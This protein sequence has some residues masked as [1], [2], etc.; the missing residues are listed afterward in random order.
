MTTPLYKKLKE[1]GTSFYAFASAAEDISAAYQ[2]DNYRMY[3]SKYV[4]LNFPKQ[5]TNP[6]GTQAVPT[7]FDFATFSTI[8]PVASISYQDQVIE[9]LRNYVA[10]N[11]VTLR[12]S[13]LNNTEYYYDTRALETTSEKI[14]W[15]WCKKLNLIDYEPAIP[16]DEYFSNLTE[17]QRVDLTDDSYF[18]EYLWKEKEPVEISVSNYDTNI[19]T[20]VGNLQ[21]E[22]NQI[23]SI[24]KGDVIEL[25][26][27]SDLGPL[28]GAIW[29]GSLTWL[30]TASMSVLDVFEIA[31]IQY[32]VVDFIYSGGPFIE[33]SGKVKVKYNKLIQ[34][35]GEVTGVSNVQE[36]NRAYTEVYAHVPDHT[37]QTPDIL[38]RTIADINYK[39]GMIF[40]IIPSQYQPEIIGAEL[41]SSPIV[42]NPTQ[43]PG[44]YYGQFDTID[45][46]YECE[47]G[48]TLRRS[49]KY[50]GVSGDINAPVI[51]GSTL[52]GVTVDF[53]TTHYAKMNIND[54]E[55]ATFDEFNALEI[56][57]MP[58]VDFEFNAILWYY[59]VEDLNGNR[60]TNLYGI[61]F[62]DNPDNN[63]KQDEIAIRF[64]VYKK[65]VTNGSQDGTSYAFGLN[66]NFN[67]IH[68]NP[69]E[70]Y[71][72][73][74]I[75]SLFSM[76]LFNESM[77]R[78]GNIN[79][80]FSNILAEQTNLQSELLNIK[81]L[82]YSQTDLNTINSKIAN[83]EQLL[84]SY[85][86][87]QLVSSDTIQV[88]TLDSSPAQ[89]RLNSIDAQ[90][91]KI[92]TFNTSDMYNVNGAIP[93][94]ISPPTNKD[95]LVHI[96]NNDQVDITL[97]NSDKL[98]L[99]VTTD[100]SYKQT[101]NLL[102]SGSNLSTQN[103]KLDVFITTVNLITTTAT[104]SGNTI[105]E[106][107]LTPPVET[108]LIGDID[109]PVF[110]NTSTTQPNSAATWKGFNFDINFNSDIQLLA[111]N[112][113]Q[114]NLNSNDLLVSNSVKVGDSVVLNN[115]FI[116]T[117]STFD[118]SGQYKVDSVVGATVSLNVSNNSNF[119]AYASNSYPLVI[120]QPST[121]TSILSNGPYLSLN[122]GY[123]I[124]ITR[125]SEDDNVLIPQKYFVDVRELQ[126]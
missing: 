60:R 90:Y 97:P 117:V 19:T 32:V 120:H 14:F 34:Y 46:T 106:E 62:L 59:T 30:G 96:I 83:L 13:R 4:L 108:L 100:L 64:P 113:L 18:P 110:Y 3:F 54:R 91:Y 61:S 95:F 118:F 109:L 80:S 67:I 23:T 77:R 75:N 10:N 43:Y 112:L 33:T 12:E 107:T 56:N 99:L 122:K 41:F 11:E 21:L 126:Y 53:N 72:P 31:G 51:D 40:P 42:S 71:N 63:P 87:M 111:G 82:L 116:G 44:S 98:S 2:N 74:A 104:S 55:V 45:F 57:N 58:P 24:S 94:N 27:F 102:I 73:E 70:A 81:Q 6:G 8:A 89:L 84:Q 29:N 36:A 5:Q 86:S 68:D 85:A 20:F 47:S 125:I 105:T 121:S 9:S 38:F 69:Q 119:V 93:I 79:E 76:N 15:K 50:Y 65:L 124:R 52:D 101:M 16:T 25:Y 48:D 17:F 123:F 7:Y 39:P 92:E 22:L 28:T 49:G 103:K 114:F 26:D 37:G 35:I 1:N 66:L 115:L 78:L 88:E